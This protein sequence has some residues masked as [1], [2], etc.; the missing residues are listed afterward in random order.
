M[1]FCSDYK[2]L[3][4]SWIYFCDGINCE[5]E[6]AKTAPC[7]SGSTHIL[8][9]FI[10]LLDKHKVLNCLH[11]RTYQVTGE[12]VRFY[13]ISPHCHQNCFPILI[14]DSALLKIQK[15]VETP[16]WLL[17]LCLWTVTG[18]N[19]KPPL[20]EFQIKQMRYLNI[21]EIISETANSSRTAFKDKQ[22]SILYCSNAGLSFT[23]PEEAT[24]HRK[25]DHSARLMPKF[26]T[27]PDKPADNF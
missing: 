16:F 20:F 19:K 5:G 1:A 24:G 26:T 10:F 3:S 27:Y 23:F 14:V 25:V 6:H 21:G 7:Y 12:R 18:E 4:S 11:F 8:S 22:W 2:I 9:V 15:W 13:F 17:Q